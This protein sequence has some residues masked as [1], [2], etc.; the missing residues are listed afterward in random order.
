M[1]QRIFAN[2]EIREI[3]I[4][5]PDGHRHLR[6]VICLQDGEELVFQEATIANLVR[7]FVAVKTHPQE[8]GVILTGTSLEQDQ[9][10]EGFA[11]WQLLEKK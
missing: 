10:K 5:T 7:A 8:R 9:R 2:E 1:S 4:F 6:T 11:R 3:A